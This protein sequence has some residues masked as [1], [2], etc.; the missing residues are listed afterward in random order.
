MKVTT[1]SNAAAAILDRIGAQYLLT[2]AGVL[3]SGASLSSGLTGRR[4]AMVIALTGWRSQS[5]VSNLQFEDCNQA[6]IYRYLRTEAMEELLCNYRM[7]SLLHTSVSNVWP[8]LT[9]SQPSQVVLIKDPTSWMVWED[10][11]ADRGA[12]LCNMLQFDRWLLCKHRS[13]AVGAP[14]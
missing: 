11:H 3:C 5:E 2:R 14:G 8:S 4:A 7:S 12:W 1:A 6:I 13:W 9:C 10:R